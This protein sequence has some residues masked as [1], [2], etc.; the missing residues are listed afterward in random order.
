MR[1]KDIVINEIPADQVVEYECIATIYEDLTT[2]YNYKIVFT[3]KAIWAKR[4]RWALFDFGT[5]AECI[6]Y[7]DISNIEK[8]KFVRLMGYKIFYHGTTKTDKIYFNEFTDKA[9]EII[10]SHIK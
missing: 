4:P 8:I 5:K 9:G 1:A 7:K 3:D 2:A 6:P 10:L